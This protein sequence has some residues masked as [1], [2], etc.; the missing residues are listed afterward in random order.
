MDMFRGINMHAQP[1]CDYYS[2]MDLSNTTLRAIQD[3]LNR[4]LESVEINAEDAG[5]GSS[6]M[7]D[8]PQN[9]D[10]FGDHDEQGAGDY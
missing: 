8:G 4:G 9:Y 1:D 5:I 3:L 10:R 2:G 6:D 7:G